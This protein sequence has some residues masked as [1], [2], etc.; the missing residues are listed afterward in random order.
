MVTAVAYAHLGLP[1]PESAQADLLDGHTVAT[2]D[3]QYAGQG[4]DGVD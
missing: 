3:S 4:E 1:A 2:N